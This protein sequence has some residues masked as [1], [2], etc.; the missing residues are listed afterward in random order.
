MEQMGARLVDAGMVDSPE[1]AREAASLLKK[2]D[3]EL[4]FIY[5]S[6]YTLSSTFLPI[7]QKLNVPLIILNLQ[8]VPAIDYEAFN[9][10]NDRGK[11]TGE[12]LAHCQARS[13][14]ELAN[15]RYEFVNKKCASHENHGCFWSRRVVLRILCDGFQR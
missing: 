13:V 5:V 8:A 1:K 4:V 9:K 10:L 15:L 14:P 3:V 6:T 7:A 12:W 11:M 2:E